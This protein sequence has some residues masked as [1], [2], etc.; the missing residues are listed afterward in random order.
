VE[1]NT[2][3][4]ID[5]SELAYR[6]Y[7]AFKR[8][9]LI[10]SKGQNT[11][12]IFGFSQSLLKLLK[13]Y[14]PTHIAVAFDSSAPTFR[15]AR[16]PSY[17]AT[18]DKMPD[19][20]REQLDSIREVIQSL[21]VN[22]VEEPGYEA[23][24]VMATLAVRAAERGWD[25]V[26]VSGDKDMLQV[27]G[28]RIRVLNPRRDFVFYDAEG[29][30][31]RYRVPP[32]RIPDLFALTGDA[33]D[34]VPGVPGVG[35]KSGADLL[36]RFGD[37]DGVLENV[38]QIT[39]RRIRENIKKVVD[40]IRLARELICLDSQV[41]LD[42]PLSDLGYGD[43]SVERLR[44]L[45]HD[46]EFY[47][48]INQVAGPEVRKITWHQL[49]GTA[50]LEEMIELAKAAG[51][52]S[53]ELV[54]G[55]SGAPVG[56]AIS[57]R[58]GEGIYIPLSTS[59]E[60]KLRAILHDTE[61]LKVT[62]DAKPALK[63][64]LLTGLNLFDISIASYL[65]SPG[66]RQHSL[67]A[68]SEEY[69]GW[70]CPSLPETQKGLFPNHSE[71]EEAACCRAGIALEIGEQLVT[72]LEELELSTLFHE[73]EMPLVEVLAAMEQ[74]GVLVDRSF[75]HEMSSSL[76]GELNRL[77]RSIYELAGE[78]FN[79]RSPIQLRH[80]LFEKLGLPPF[81]RSKTGYSTDVEVLG[82]LAVEW[83]IAQRL[84]EYREVDK[85]KGT[86]VDVLP[87]LADPQTG[88][89][90]ATWHQ[91]VTATGRLSSSNPNLQNIPFRSPLGRE[92]RK[93]FI[94]PEG[95]QLL[96]ADYSQ[97]ELR[98]LAHLS[99]DRN[100]IQAFEQGGD[101][102]AMTASALFDVPP[103][104]VTVPQRSQ[105]KVVNF[106]ITYG[107]SPF[108][109]ARE[110]DIEPEEASLIIQEYFRTYPEVAAWI[111]SE[112]EEARR[113]GYV[114]TLLGRRREVLE[115]NSRS[116]Q[117]REFAERIAVNTPIQGT[118]ADLIKKAMVAI[119]RDLRNRG[120]RS[121]MVLQ[122]HDELV[123]EVP[124]DERDQAESLLVEHMQEALSLRVPLVVRVKAGDN[125]YQAH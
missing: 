26:I 104:Q 87:R 13:D 54:A 25:V 1:S 17:K 20:M 90:H 122:I 32:E 29:V 110:L 77:Q 59:I 37:V 103:D 3:F 10:N 89:V 73:I 23:D 123:L 71:L 66:R 85:L 14:Q 44:E 83:E 65:L 22:I 99:G 101:I 31:K 116:R 121:R 111:E 7:F 24:D 88:R 82:K 11:S 64:D 109:L 81:K 8:N 108:G 74:W 33:I 9:P 18:R 76:E 56:I 2:L 115:L 107:M 98:I 41:P 16:Y 84:L 38:E 67:E 47:S 46:L 119:H 114:T 60:S 94:A 27:I 50:E 93:A 112:L 120:L 48:L 68:V 96:S 69:L 79:I 102:H 19:D 105:A 92:V 113:L 15:H 78:E 75:L 86:Y 106:G 72:R 95:W 6:S 58:K 100:L 62:S 28:D 49:A 63:G 57:V 61:L 118:A 55:P 124:E 12:A 91:T 4:L 53:L 30:L 42:V 117:R 125:W 51:R 43:F 21:G 39:Q 52:L 70:S 80:I 40:Q 36:S 97:V 35:P 34:N 45:F 5:G